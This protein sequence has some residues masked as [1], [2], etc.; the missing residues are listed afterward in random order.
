[1]SCT[2]NLFPLNAFTSKVALLLEAI[3]TRYGSSVAGHQA[4]TI[5]HSRNLEFIAENFGRFSIASFSPNQYRHVPFGV[6]FESSVFHREAC[7]ISVRMQRNSLSAA[8]MTHPRT[9]IPHHC[10]GGRPPQQQDTKA[11]MMY[12][13]EEKSR[14]FLAFFTTLDTVIARRMELLKDTRTASQSEQDT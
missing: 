2:T 1:L 5:R 8:V 11:W 10:R 14:H 9:F 3:S 13:V 7:L 4:E 12:T 6:V